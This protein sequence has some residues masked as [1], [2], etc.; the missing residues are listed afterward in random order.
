M[1]VKPLLSATLAMLLTATASEAA[2]LPETTGWSQLPNTQLRSVCAAEE[3]FGQ[4]SGNTGCDAITSAWSGGAFDTKRNRL[5]I[6]GGGHSDYYGNELYAVN[7]DTQTISRITDPGLPK[8]PS[9]PCAS[10]IAGGTQPNSRHTY[11]GVEYIASRDKLFAFGGSLACDSG[12]FGK[13]TWTFDFA[14]MKW[15]QMNPA[16]PIPAGDAGMMT[17]YDPNSGLVYLHDRINL[18]TYNV[19]SNAYTR[20]SADSVAI[21][22]DLNATYD[23]K[24]KKFVIVGWDETQGAGRVYTYDVGAGASVTAKSIN[25]SGG[26][27]VIAT[28]S[29]GLAYDPGSDRIVAWSEKSPNVIYSLNLDTNQWTTTTYSGGPAPAGNGTNGRL[30]YAPSQGVFVLAN[31]VDN[32]VYVMRM[33]PAPLKPMPPTSLSVQ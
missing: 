7:L 19:D 11:D 14:T 8:A 20:I 3:G 16:G 30:R 29:P 10:S 25:T 31:K 32:N 12:N 13:D 27:T 17:A 21:G 5:I 4:I 23:P 33:G 9:S 28:Q 18:Y 24:R 6:W 2:T 1:L 26:S 15:Q 22:W